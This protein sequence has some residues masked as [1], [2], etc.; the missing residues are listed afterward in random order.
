MLGIGDVV[1]QVADVTLG[2]GDVVYHVADVMLR[3]SDVVLRR[4]RGRRQNL[5]PFGSELPIFRFPPVSRTIRRQL[6]NFRNRR[7]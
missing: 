5:Q 6:S 4:K 3:V 2:I 7:R 1:F